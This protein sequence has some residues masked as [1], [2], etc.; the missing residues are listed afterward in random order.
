MESLGEIAFG[1]FTVFMLIVALKLTT[2][3][4]KHYSKS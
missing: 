1:A 3:K 4:H 2:Q